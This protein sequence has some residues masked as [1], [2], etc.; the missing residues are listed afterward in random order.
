MY[1]IPARDTVA[2]EATALAK[3]RAVALDLAPVRAGLAAEPQDYPWSGHHHYRT[4]NV[5]HGLFLGIVKGVEQV[6]DIVAHGAH[7]IGWD[8][9]LSWS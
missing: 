3:L 5:V 8:G 9:D 4:F 1:T 7:S 2:G 6:G